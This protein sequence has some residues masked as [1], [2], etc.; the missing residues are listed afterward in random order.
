MID[1]V[2][3]VCTRARD[4]YVA[5]SDD[6]PPTLVASLTSFVSSLRLAD[7]F[8]GGFYLPPPPPPPLPPPVA[9]V[10]AG[11]QE[12]VGG[13]SDGPS[14]VAGAAAAAVAVAVGGEEESRP[15]AAEKGKGKE[16]D[17][18]S[19]DDSTPPAVPLIET[20]S[21]ELPA[22][23]PGAA[24][25]STSSNAA[26]SAAQQRVDATPATPTSTAESNP[27]TP[28]SPIAEQS[29]PSEPSTP[30]PTAAAAAAAKTTTPTASSSS[31][32]PPSFLSRT[33]ST[34]PANVRP[35]DAPF[36]ELPPAMTVLLLPFHELLDSNKTFCSLVYNDRSE[37]GGPSLMCLVLAGF[38]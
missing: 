22:T 18:S 25:S 9:A 24:S 1:V 12:E 30:A 14:T 28:S 15:T 6:A 20:S 26:S 33:S 11:E 3:T 29:K 36:V 8:S 13:S 31:S 35:E 7:L 17:V 2:S 38:Q 21:V 5:T 23:G 19:L 37:G 32:R 27:I 16:K 10:T 4:A 34:R